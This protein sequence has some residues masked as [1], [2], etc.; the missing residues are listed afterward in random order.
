MMWSEQFAAGPA[1]S[2]YNNM[3]YNSMRLSKSAP[4]SPIKPTSN[5][6]AARVDPFHIVHKVPVGDSPY[7]KAKHVQLVD[8]DP[9]RAIAL[10]WAAI[11]SGDRVDSALKDMAIVMK[12]QNRP[13]E[14]IEAIKSL[15][16]RCSDQAQ[17]SLDNVLLDLF[18]RCGRLEDQ[19]DLLKHKLHLIHQGM[20]FNGK[21]TKTA[22]SQ[23]KKFQ[24]SVEQEA[25]R[26]LGNLKKALNLD[27][28]PLQV[29]VCAR[30]ALSIESDNNKVCNLGICLMK[31]GR[32]EEAK[33][34]LETVTP[35]G[36][37]GR[38][39]S[40][41]HMKSYERAQE[42]LEELET[43]MSAKNYLQDIEKQLSSFAIS[44]SET[45][46]ASIH[47]SSLWQPQP[48]L[49][50]Q[51]RRI[52]RSNL[53]LQLSQANIDPAMKGAFLATSGFGPQQPHDSTTPHG[54]A[55]GRQD[56]A[57]SFRRQPG[58]MLGEESLFQSQ[59]WLQGGSR[60]GSSGGWE[61]EYYLDYSSPDES[62][63]GSDAQDAQGCHLLK[64]TGGLS[65]I[66]NE[67]MPWTCN[68]EP[69][70]RL[71]SASLPPLHSAPG[72]QSR[73]TAPPKQDDKTM[74]TWNM[75]GFTYN[76]S[77]LDLGSP[78]N[79]EMGSPPNG[80][81]PDSPLKSLNIGEHKGLNSMESILASELEM[82][83]QRRLRVF[84]EMTL[85]KT[86]QV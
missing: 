23:G 30:K 56:T 6:P 78:P 22:R 67:E 11:N 55:S 31:Q 32:L 14:A 65:D 64:H 25:T 68:D 21:R 66:E 79:G 16:S 28:R 38:W 61:D 45:D 76:P 58:A 86:L 81:L 62:S 73:T 8:R 46:A 42:M 59:S 80:R 37:D 54:V 40:D 13:Q 2:G 83:Q 24:V 29:F 57:G 5:R 19:I 12:Q 69:S 71:Q 15:R 48:A 47:D 34:M 36:S 26:L 39:A 17:E 51:P 70:S 50:R 75:M 18:K 20:A 4:C 3:P 84:Q 9:D 44:G 60:G 35:A 7:V 74:S 72:K 77:N 41:S 1:A 33:S 63:D 53:E 82:R 49:P 10:F 43:S 52:S 85:S 27:A